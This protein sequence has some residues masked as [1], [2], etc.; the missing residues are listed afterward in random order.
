MDRSLKI[1]NKIAAALIVLL[2]VAACSTSNAPAPAQPEPQGNAQ[3]DAAA[4]NEQPPVQEQDKVLMENEAFR[5]FEPVPEAEVGKS[6]KVR[7]EARVFEAS[8]SYTFEDGHNIL[9]SGHVQADKGAPEW[10]S[11]EF[12]ISYEEATSPSGVLTLYV[13]S[14]KDGAPSNEL[15]IPLKLPMKAVE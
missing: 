4:P 13:A 12:T 7:G 6:F 3:P 15:H 10:G 1:I 14:A 8:F 11:F 2:I 9:S 5:L